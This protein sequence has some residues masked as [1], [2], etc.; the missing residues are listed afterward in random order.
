MPARYNV[1]CGC[2]WWISAKSVHSS[3]ISCRD[4]FLKNSKIKAKMFKA[5]GLVKKHITFMK[6]IKIQWCHMG[7]IFLPNNMIWQRQK[8][9]HIHSLIVHFHTGNVYWGAVPTVHVAIFLTKKNIKNMKKHHPELGFT[10][11]T[12]LDGVL[13]MVEIHWKTK[14]YVTRVNKNLHQMNLQKYTPEKS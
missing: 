14:T 4:R 7:V 1:M 6:H 12:S 9:A 2:K 11:I 3:L 10:F 8:C 13:L 5:E